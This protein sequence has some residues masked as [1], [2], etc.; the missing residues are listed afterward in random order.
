MEL[1][2]LAALGVE[3]MPGEVTT[4][5]SVR[6]DT[7][8]RP[9]R[10]HP[11][12]AA[13]PFVVDAGSSPVPLFRPGPDDVA[14]L[15][16]HMCTPLGVELELEASPTWEAWTDADV[17]ARELQVRHYSRVVSAAPAALFPAPRV[18]RAVQELATVSHMPNVMED[19][20]FY[21]ALFFWLD[22]RGRFFARTPDVYEAFSEQAPP[23]TYLFFYHHDTRSSHRPAEGSAWAGALRDSDRVLAER[24][25]FTDFMHVALVRYTTQHRDIHNFISHTLHKNFWMMMHSRGF[26][27]MHVRDLGALFAAAA[28]VAGSPLAIHF[29]P[30]H[31]RAGDPLFVRKEVTRKGV[32]VPGFW[33]HVLLHPRLAL[34]PDWVAAEPDR[35]YRL[36]LLRACLA[37]ILPPQE[38][39]ALRQKL[40]DALRRD[41]EPASLARCD[42]VGYGD[43]DAVHAPRALTAVRLRYC[44]FVRKAFAYLVPP[45]HLLPEWRLANHDECFVDEEIALRL[46]SLCRDAPPPPAR[47]DPVWPGET[48]PGTTALARRYLS[49]RCLHRL[50][51]P[52]AWALAGRPDWRALVASIEQ[53]RA[54]ARSAVQF[55]VRKLPAAAAT[56]VGTAYRDWD[57]GHELALP[58]D[59]GLPPLVHEALDMA[60]RLHRAHVAVPLPNGGAWRRGLAGDAGDRKEPGV[61]L[62]DTLATSIGRALNMELRGR[63]R[64]GSLEQ[65]QPGADVLT[66]R[67]VAALRA[68]QACVALPPALQHKL[69]ALEAGAVERQSSAL[70]SPFREVYHTLHSALV[71]GSLTSFA[72]ES[73]FLTLAAQ[74]VPRPLDEINRLLVLVLTDFPALRTTLTADVRVNHQPGSWL[75]KLPHVRSHYRR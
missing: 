46:H 61:A 51:E 48:R 64:M 37:Y 58:P 24:L 21:S 55:I 20:V 42:T 66:V 74:L 12:P 23:F 15:Q 32:A 39:V 40:K 2:F 67:Q 8:P 31:L 69:A 59:L 63:A 65:M 27:R 70:A 10:L 4:L 29:K 52:E 19:F 54:D 5:S 13:H 53:L 30:V 16:P 1:D 49:L 47:A 56:A 44:F 57:L 28:N 62:L 38:F 45:L 6:W 14:G 68:L 41:T 11:P 36:C 75:L 26:G 7:A 17:C 35:A 25:S 72:V 3:E 71:A 43:V 33:T 22:A 34:V 50:G 60:L 73:L 18:L 9:G